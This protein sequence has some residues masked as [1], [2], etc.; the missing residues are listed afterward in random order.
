MMSVFVLKIS[1]GDASVV[2][3]GF[4]NRPPAMGPPDAFCFLFPGESP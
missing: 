3:R 2:Q 4:Y 1:F